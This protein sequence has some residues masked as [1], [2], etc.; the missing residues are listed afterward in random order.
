MFAALPYL[1]NLVEWVSMPVIFIILIAF[2]RWLRRRQRVELGILYI[3]FCLALSIWL[4]YLFA[5]FDMPLK[6][7]VVRHGGA[8]V[9]LLGTLF[10]LALVRRY[11]WEGWFE[12]HNQTKAPK[13]LSELVALIVFLSAALIVIGGIYGKSI[14]GAVFG[15]TVVLGVI[16]FAMQD[17]LGNIIAGIA[18]EIG[19]PFK[20]GDWLV[21]DGR[22][23]EVIEVNWR[24]TRLRNNDDVY[25]DIPNKHIAGATIVNLTFPTRE[26]ALRLVIGFD[27][28]A[29]PNYVKDCLVRA[30]SHALGVLQK[31]A[32]KAFLKD[33]AD[34]AILYEIKFWLEDESRYSDIVDAIRTNVW[35]EA[36]RR[37]IRIPFP[38][39]T[40][41]I[42]RPRTAKPLTVEALRSPTRM[43]PFLELLD[44]AQSTRLLQSARLLR[45][46][47][48][49]RVIE[50]GEEGGSMFILNLRLLSRNPTNIN[51]I[52]HLR[53][54]I[55]MS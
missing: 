13:F 11:F 53:M 5:H 51:S 38:I 7:A 36:Q 52:T 28:N 55:G 2:G 25:I 32:P 41:Q 4:P 45:F 46:G 30:A 16:G 33:F 17:L 24:S 22:H 50:Q 44:D 35:Y 3:L 12:K 31:P 43:Q 6:H 19:K 1:E 18:L 10:V 48:G 20:P 40:V 9:L 34:S 15:S 37:G 54:K 14:E 39:R 23:A 8:A 26:H 27:Y 42:E 47:R 21:V 29:P 49:E